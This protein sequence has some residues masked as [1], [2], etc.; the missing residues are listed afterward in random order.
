MAGKITVPKLDSSTF[1]GWA[2]VLVAGCVLTV[3]ALIDAG[4]FGKGASGSTGCV[5]IVV[6]DTVNVRQNPGVELAPVGELTKG[7][8]V[9]AQRNVVNGY[10][11]LTGENRWALDS[12]LSTK[13]GSSC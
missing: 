1:K 3:L 7:Q 13:A 6:S 5:M 4:Q 12:S 8:E 11:Q 2:F 10:R 9:D